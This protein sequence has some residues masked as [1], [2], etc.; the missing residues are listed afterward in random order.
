MSDMDSRGEFEELDVTEDQFDAMMDEA[1]PASVYMFRPRPGVG[2][3][4]YT[5]QVTQGGGYAS[6]NQRR[7][8][9]VQQSN[10]SPGAQPV[11][12]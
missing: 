3:A 4:L 12:S 2:P 10:T 5:V 6:V 8:V 9:S 1:E 7:A 11:S